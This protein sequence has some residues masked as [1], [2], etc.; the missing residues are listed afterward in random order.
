MMTL[1][2]YRVFWVK[3]LVPGPFSACTRTLCMHKNLGHAS[4]DARVHP[5][6]IQLGCTWA[7]RLHPA[8]MRMC[9]QAGCSLDAHVHPDRDNLQQPP[10]RA[11]VFVSFHFWASVCF[12]SL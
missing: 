11:G 12:R 2:Y 10:G 5:S 9:V 7:S 1:C 4:L 6:W 3:A 8:W